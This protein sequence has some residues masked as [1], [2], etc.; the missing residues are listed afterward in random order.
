M[1]LPKFRNQPEQPEQPEQ[2]YSPGWTSPIHLAGHLTL[3]YEGLFNGKEDARFDTNYQSI[4]TMSQ[5]YE[6]GYHLGFQYMIDRRDAG[7]NVTM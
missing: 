6:E 7:W 3:Y 2:P 5:D 1:P 4:N